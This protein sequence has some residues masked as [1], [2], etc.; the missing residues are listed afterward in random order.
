M[1]WK[2]GHKPDDAPPAMYHLGSA[3]SMMMI[4]SCVMKAI[5]RRHLE[6]AFA[7]M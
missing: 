5:S 7:S 6:V 1:M 2:C 3:A 4:M